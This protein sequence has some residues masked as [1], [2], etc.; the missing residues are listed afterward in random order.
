MYSKLKI[1]AA[2]K[3]KKKGWGCS[4]HSYR[5]TSVIHKWKRRVQKVLMPLPMQMRVYESAWI[6][7]KSLWKELQQSS[8]S[9]FQWTGKLLAKRQGMEGDLVFTICFLYILNFQHVQIL[10][11]V[12][13]Y[14]ERVAFTYIQCVK[15][16][17][18]VK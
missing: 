1:K 10:L 5:I 6:C 11:K 17:P 15:Y 12:K 16:I 14:M 4:L 3:R 9:S 2:I 7:I 18:C 8:G 13:V